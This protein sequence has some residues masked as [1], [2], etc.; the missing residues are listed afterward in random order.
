MLDLNYNLIGDNGAVAL[1][2]NKQ[3]KILFLGNNQITNIGALAL[4]KS[5]LDLLDV[6]YNHIGPTGL[7][8]LKASKIITVLAEGNDGDTIRHQ[9]QR[10]KLQRTIH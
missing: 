4:A 5:S 1:A 3:L 2:E 7:Q 8:A 6:T 10:T 9:A